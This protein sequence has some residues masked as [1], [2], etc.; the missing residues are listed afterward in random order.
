MARLSPTI[1]NMAFACELAFK[2]LLSESDRERI[3][4]LKDL[5]DKL[6]IS[7]QE[8]IK[9]RVVGEMKTF[10]QCWMSVAITLL[11]GDIFMSIIIVETSDV[12]T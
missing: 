4:K 3:R 12:S 9:A 2:S 1:M 11:T 10:I 5:Y 8:D 6:V 7:Y